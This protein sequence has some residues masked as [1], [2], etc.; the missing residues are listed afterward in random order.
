MFGPNKDVHT[1]DIIYTTHTKIQNHVLQ[2]F[3]IE[4][5]ASGIQSPPWQF[6]SSVYSLYLDAEGKSH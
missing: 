5:E 2:L 4:K 6:L 1:H 3:Q